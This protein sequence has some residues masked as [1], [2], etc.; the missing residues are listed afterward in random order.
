MYSKY[1]HNYSQF[2]KLNN[3]FICICIV[4]KCHYLVYNVANVAYVYKPRDNQEI[5]LLCQKIIPI[6]FK[7]GFLCLLCTK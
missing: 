7:W 3:E 1:Q 2:G 6:N 4:Q 5:F